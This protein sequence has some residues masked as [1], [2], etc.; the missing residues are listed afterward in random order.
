MIMDQ[1]NFKE[2]FNSSF[3]SLKNSK[4]SEFIAIDALFFLYQASSIIIG[5]GPRNRL[6]RSLVEGRDPPLQQTGRNGRRDQQKV[7]RSNNTRLRI[8]LQPKQLNPEPVAL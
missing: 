8:K 2:I 1:P 6:T 3:T 5:H 4:G 7:I